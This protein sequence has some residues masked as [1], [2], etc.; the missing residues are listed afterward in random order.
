LVPRVQV[1]G[2]GALCSGAGMGHACLV[3][4]CCARHILTNARAHT[5]RGGLWHHWRQVCHGCLHKQVAP[6][7]HVCETHTHVLI[8]CVCGCACQSAHT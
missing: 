6:V 5:H 2:S 1:A 8:V 4:A 3:A 7:T